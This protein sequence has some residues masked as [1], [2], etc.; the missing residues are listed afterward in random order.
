MPLHSVLLKLYV[1]CRTR[2]SCD[3][4][5]C[6]TLCLWKHAKLRAI[7]QLGLGGKNKIFFHFWRLM[8]QYL[9]LFSAPYKA[10]PFR[11]NL[12]KLV[13]GLNNSKQNRHTN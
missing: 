2:F 13:L 10:E 3:F 11:L 6:L 8:T 5:K 1:H 12:G 9:V 7:F 4:S